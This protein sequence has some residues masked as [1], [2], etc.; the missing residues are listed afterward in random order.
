MKT[1]GKTSVP[2]GAFLLERCR[3]RMDPA[4]E[5]SSFAFMLIFESDDTPCSFFCG[6]HKERE[7]WVAAL[8]KAS[9]EG[10]RETLCSLRG[11]LMDL[12]GEDPLAN[13]SFPYCPP[14]GQAAENGTLQKRPLSTSLIEESID[15]PATEISPVLELSMSCRDLYCPSGIGH[16]NTFG[17]LS[18]LTPP[19]T[20]WSKHAQTEVVESNTSPQYFTNVTF[21]PGNITM[22]SR[23]KVSIYYVKEKSIDPIAPLLLGNA[24]F[25]VSNIVTAKQQTVE[26]SLR[27]GDC[28]ISTG[29]VVVQAWKM[30]ESPEPVRRFT[31]PPRPKS[32]PASHINNP[33]IT[34]DRALSMASGIS[35]NEATDHSISHRLSIR[36]QFGK[37]ITR[38]YRFPTKDRL[39]FLKV[40]EIM[41]EGRYT[42]TVPIQLL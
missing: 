8:K 10:L 28:E 36:Q 16:L 34:S 40:W 23:I 30:V 24:Q 22:M 37:T 9:Y 42:W 12:T 25:T 19:Q 29:Y 2:V 38:S 18:V 20:A 1:A 4:N 13:D 17:V 15:S 32:L 35:R 41:G 27:R 31:T 33:S 26:K 7:E 21:F 6:S 5:K 3:V 11:Q 39:A 14:R